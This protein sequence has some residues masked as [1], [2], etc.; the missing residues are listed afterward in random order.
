[1]ATAIE[2]NDESQ[3]YSE[4]IALLNKLDLLNKP[5]DKLFDYYMF[6]F[7][8]QK[9]KDHSNEIKKMMKNYNIDDL[10]IL[11]NIRRLT[12]YIAHIGDG[13]SAYANGGEA[14]KGVVLNG[15]LL[16]LTYIFDISTTNKKISFNGITCKY[17]E[18]DD[19]KTLLIKKTPHF[20]KE[21]LSLMA[22]VKKT[23]SKPYRGSAI[24]MVKNIKVAN[25]LNF[26]M[27]FDSIH[28]ALLLKELLKEEY[29]YYMSKSYLDL[30]F[31]TMLS[32]EIVDNDANLELTTQFYSLLRRRAFL[33]PHGGISLKPDEMDY[34]IDLFERQYNGDNY[35][36]AIMTHTDVSNFTVIN[37]SKNYTISNCKWMYDVC[38][39]LYYFYNMADVASE[40]YGSNFTKDPLIYLSYEFEN[41]LGNELKISRGTAETYSKFQVTVPYYWRYRGIKQK[42]ISSK[43]FYSNQSETGDLT[44]IAAFKRKLPKGSSASAGAKEL[45]KIYCIELGE[46]ETLVKPFVRLGRAR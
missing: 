7:L 16:F 4:S 13:V 20:A 40:L 12:T 39:F 30:N 37:L 8:P 36:I 46:N 42:V 23:S 2:I 45:S 6:K 10:V 14:L 5:F 31:L 22:A 34:E 41:I 25:M 27:K 26:K 38:N 3:Y 32:L 28:L 18:L 35:L 24:E 19:C 43:D 9:D 33:I 1:M 21:L 17:G 11:D 15:Y 29:S 44:Y